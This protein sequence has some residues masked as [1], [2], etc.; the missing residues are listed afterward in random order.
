VRKLGLLAGVAGALLALYAVFGFLVAPSLVRSTLVQRAAAAGYDLRVGKVAINPFSLA[1]RADDMRLAPR[2]GEPF[3]SARRVSVDLAG[4]TSLWRRTWIVDALRLEE[5]V[6]S[7]LPGAGAPGGGSRRFAVVVRELAITGGVL[8]LPGVP[9]LEHIALQARDLSP[10]EEHQNAFSI[11]AGVASGGTAKSDGTLSLSPLAGD[12]E[13]QLD[14]AS[15]AEAWHYLPPPAGKAPPGRIS[16]SL[17]Y[18]YAD[19]KLALS[20]ADVQAT[21][22]S[23]GRLALRGALTAAPLEAQLALEAKGVPLSLAEPWLA[24][25]SALRI[26]GGALDAHGTL[27]LGNDA[28]YEGAATIRDAR[29]DGPQGELVAWQT[30]GTTHLRLGLAPFSLHADEMLARAPRANVVIAPDGKLNL[31]APFAA[32]GQTGNATPPARPA[33]TI[34][35][36]RVENGR[37]DLADRTLA[38]PFATSVRDLAGALAGL[39]TAEDAPARVE[40]NGRVGK[41]GEARVRGALEPVA[42]ATRTNLELRLRNLALADFTPYAVKFAGYRIEA[43]QLSATLRYRVREGR[44]IGSNEL[45]FDRLQL[46]EKVESAGALDLPVDLAVALLTDAQGRIN[47]AVPVTGD[48]RDPQFDLGGLIAKAMRNTLAKI[49]SAPFRALASLLGHDTAA[50]ELDHVSFDPGAASLAPPEEE[51]LARIAE[52]LVARPQLGLSVHAGYDPQSDTQALKR[53]TVLREVA[54]RAG[55][56][57]AAGGGAPAALDLRDAKIRRAAEGLYLARVG[58]A[59]ELGSLKPREQGYGQRLI[60]ALAAKTE[61]PADA[62]A[63]LAQRRAQAVRDAL[64]KGGIDEARI[65]VADAASLQAVDDGVP[66]RLALDSQ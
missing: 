19:A 44:L 40:L 53:A 35:R 1:A 3:F 45:E 66:T 13:L 23:G 15:L 21:L 41:Y 4:A 65:H 42:P 30:L 24:E 32:G 8:A 57:A 16:G 49:I 50:G 39:S 37:L 12:G 6:L 27:H 54:K 61:V 20:N 7:A 17:H 46:G 22:E 25:R 48:L 55:Y 11:N 36:V 59:F 60:A 51:K 52:A 5:P 31:A 56:S 26:A 63:S 47:L 14:G 9:R 28:R 10:I 58:T 33:V 43:G 18:R 29:I 62:S 64:V 2:D 34:G 38:P